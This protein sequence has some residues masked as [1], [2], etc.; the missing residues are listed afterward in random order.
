MDFKRHK[1]NP[2]GEDVHLLHDGNVKRDEDSIIY[3]QRFIRHVLYRP[4]G[5]MY[6]KAKNDF[7][8]RVVKIKNVETGSDGSLGTVEKRQS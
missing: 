3:I 2:V 1:K 7:E 8:N 6:E 4:G 5:P